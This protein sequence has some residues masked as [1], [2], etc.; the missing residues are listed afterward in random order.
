MCRHIATVYSNI[1]RD[2]YVGKVAKMFNLS[3]KSIQND[4]ERQ[5]RQLSKD[6]AKKRHDELIKITSGL[7]D[8]VNPDYA[9]VPKAARTEEVILGM[10]ILHRE[11]AGVSVNGEPLSVNEL[12]TELGKRI[13]TFITKCDPGE[14]SFGAMN[15]EFTEAEISRAV[16]MMEKRRGL[17]CSSETYSEYVKVLRSEN[18]KNPNDGTLSLDD[19]LKRKRNQQ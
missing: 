9:R 12:A 11:L 1:E 5:R 18:E 7:G 2:I 15:E 14:F 4:V 16:G 6:K 10:L 13:F 8:T 17:N 19:I 3:V